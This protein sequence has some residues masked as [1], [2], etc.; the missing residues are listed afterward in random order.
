MNFSVPPEISG[1]FKNSFPVV[2]EGHFSGAVKTS[3][4]FH[5]DDIDFFTQ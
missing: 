5:H 3:S 1:S 2:G 4:I